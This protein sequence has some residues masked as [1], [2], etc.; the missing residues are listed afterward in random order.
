MAGRLITPPAFEPVTLDEAKAHVKQDLDTDD[1]LITTLIQVARERAEYLTG[2]AFMKQT[3]EEVLERFPPERV[4]QLPRWPLLSVE[5]VKYFDD[6]GQELTLATTEYYV[7]ATNEP[8]RIGLQKEKY[9]PTDS[10]QAGEGV[11]IRYI[12]GETAEDEEEA[13]QAAIPRGIKQLVLFLVDHFYAHR[14]VISDARYAPIP[15]TLNDLA[16]QYR[17]LQVA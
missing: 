10:L 15:E 12:A 9:W 14:G 16:W 1:A 5:H 8:G 6:E 4:I 7:D 2:R 17:V 3:W 13:Q 11:V